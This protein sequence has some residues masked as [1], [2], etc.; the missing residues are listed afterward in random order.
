[1]RVLEIYKP[2]S[3][4][5]HADGKQDNPSDRRQRQRALQ[6]VDTGRQGLQE[7]DGNREI[8]LAPAS[9]ALGVIGLPFAIVGL[10]DWI[11]SI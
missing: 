10:G 11:R 4:T 9:T 3:N 2:S 1:M 5:V 6:I 8:L 7:K